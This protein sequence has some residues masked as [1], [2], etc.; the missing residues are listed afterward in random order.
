MAMASARDARKAV[1]AASTKPQPSAAR[2]LANLP[3]GI[4]A[5]PPASTNCR[6]SNVLLSVLNSVKNGIR[7]AGRRI[8]ARP[9]RSRI[10]MSILSEA[11]WSGPHPDIGLYRLNNRS[12]PELFV[13][14]ARFL[15]R[16][17]DP[18]DQCG[19]VSNDGETYLPCIDLVC[20]IFCHGAESAPWRSSLPKSTQ[21]HRCAR[22]G[23]IAGVTYRRKIATTSTLRI[24]RRDETGPCLW[25][26]VHS[27]APEGG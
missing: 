7:S 21:M 19:L 15:A 14:D 27:A 18:E 5:E 13:Q 24:S 10:F 2:R 23:D 6:R 16:H 26:P 4:I 8:T 17:C 1:Q 3:S 11:A 20:R 25:P 22:R 9:W 12:G